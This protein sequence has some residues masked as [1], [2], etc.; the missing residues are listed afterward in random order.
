MSTALATQTQQEFFTAEQSKMIRDSFL[1][2]A[3][4]AEATVL[5][6]LARVRRLNP[7][8]R[9]IHFV[10]R[11][12][13]DK[14]REVWS[15]QVGIDGFRAIAERTGLYEG[16]DEPEFEY[17]AKGAIKLC[18]V[19]VYRKGWTRPAVGVAHFSEYAQF[20]KDGSLTKMWATKGHIMVAKCAEALAFRKAFAEDTS[21]L[22]TSEEMDQEE[23]DITP[24]NGAATA[25]LKEKVLAAANT[26]PITVKRDQAARDVPVPFTDIRAPADSAAKSDL[27]AKLEASLAATGFTPTTVVITPFERIK[28]TGEFHG[29]T[30]KALSDRVKKITGKGAKDALTH[31]DADKVA[32]AFE[33]REPGSDDG[34]PNPTAKSE[35]PF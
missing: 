20:K 13:G 15:A 12:D 11:W 35:A 1:N 5:M 22:Y 30:G 26:P 6:E 4:P 19:K 24:P 10:K 31:E 27:K 8:T 25:A 2:G 29:V 9:Q 21:G 32:A 23:K 34:P 3:S 28:A 33:P 17:D 7:I 18:R 14:N 16:Q